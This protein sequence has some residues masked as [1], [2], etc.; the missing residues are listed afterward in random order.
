MPDGYRNQRR[1]LAQPSARIHND[2]NHDNPCLLCRYWKETAWLDGETPY[3]ECRRRAPRPWMTEDTVEPVF[4][5]TSYADWCGDFKRL[6]V[7]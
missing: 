6:P 3:G 5:P 7:E 1:T 2:L 4:P